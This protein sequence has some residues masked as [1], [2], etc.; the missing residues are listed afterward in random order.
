MGKEPKWIQRPSRG[1]RELPELHGLL[2]LE[3]S[4]GVTYMF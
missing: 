4:N 2:E 1:A 3:E